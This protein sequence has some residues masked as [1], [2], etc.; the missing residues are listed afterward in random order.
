MFN[1]YQFNQY[2]FNKSIPVSSLLA[3]GDVMYWNLILHDAW[4]SYLSFMNNDDFASVDMDIF[5]NPLD[6][7]NTLSSYYLRGREITAKGSI[8]RNNGEDL[9]NELDR[10]KSVL[11]IP[12]QIL[13]VKVNGEVREAVA[14]CSGITFDRQ[15]YNINFIRYDVKFTITNESWNSRKY[16]V[17]STLWV[18]STLVEE[19]INIWR[20][21]AK[22]I[23]IVTMNSASSVDELN[24]VMWTYNITINET[25]SA[26]DIIE[27]NREDQTVKINGAEVD[28]TGRIP[29]LEQW[30]NPYTVTMTWTYSYDITIKYKKTFI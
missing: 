26:S 18:T 2:T 14:Y 27:I 23:I 10:V 5:A 22:P 15:H 8:Y 11:A 20:Y 13:S 30:R 25:L 16:Q 3:D 28:Y 9:N 4:D 17:V 19:V 21:K 24:L 29:L 7:W 12:W 1:T 6:D